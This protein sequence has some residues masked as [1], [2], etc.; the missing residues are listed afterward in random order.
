VV[1]PSPWR[2]IGHG[3]TRVEGVEVVIIDQRL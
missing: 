1:I 2:V 3:P